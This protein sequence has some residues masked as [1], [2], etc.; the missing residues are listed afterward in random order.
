M[1]NIN[2]IIEKAVDDIW[3]TYDKDNSGFLDKDEAKFFVK[4]TLTEMGENG[5]FD[6]DDF[7]ACFAAFDEDGSGT[8]SKDEMVAFIKK[9][10]GLP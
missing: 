9:V 10:A 1:S 7:E 6:D 5:E 2:K 3:K 4:T 8:I